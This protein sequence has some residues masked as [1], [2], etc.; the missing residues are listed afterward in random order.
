MIF[1]VLYIKIA[2]MIMLTK[3]LVQGFQVSEELSHDHLEI[4][5]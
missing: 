3:N 1:A 4:R 5:I 2:K